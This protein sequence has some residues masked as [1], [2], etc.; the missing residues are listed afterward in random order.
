M[1]AQRAES[2]PAEEV[3]SPGRTAEKGSGRG[4]QNVWLS[5]GM[6]G[7]WLPV[8]ALPAVWSPCAVPQLSHL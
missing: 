2:E 8:S 4:R 5:V 3:A 7:P 1:R 6:G